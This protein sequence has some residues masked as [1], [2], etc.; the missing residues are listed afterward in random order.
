MANIQLYLF[1]PSP[2][3][4]SVRMTA[5]ALGVPLELKQLNH[6]NKE[7]LSPE[8]LKTNPDHIVPT[9]TDGDFTLWES[10]AIMRYLVG[11]FGGEDNSLY[12]RDLQKRA[13]VDRLLDYDL[14]VFYRAIL[15]TLMLPVR[16]RNTPT[17]EQEEQVVKAFNRIDTL[18][19][20]K[21]FLTGDHITI[22][23]FAMV[24]GFGSEFL[25]PGDMSNYPNAMAWYKRM[26]EL[27]YYQEVNQPFFDYVENLKK[28]AGQTS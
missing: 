14:G 27:P 21:K 20:D 15:E 2:P 7:H 22:A 5:K 1:F 8:F 19:K 17:K 4:R 26:Q 23:D 6:V 24:V 18:L 9:I 10:R 13:E 3:C 16:N 11:K 25:F 12:P 28:L